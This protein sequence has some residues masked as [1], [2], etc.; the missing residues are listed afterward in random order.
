MSERAARE[1]FEAIL[2][3]YEAPLRRLAAAYEREPDRQ[4]DLLQEI[5]LALWRALPSFRGQSSERTFVYRVAHNR[6]LTHIAKRRPSQ[7]E[8]DAARDIPASSLGPEQSA[9]LRAERDELREAIA[10][11]PLALREVVLLRLEDLSN[12]EVAHVLGISE[13][14]VA[15]RLA[16]ARKQLRRGGTSHV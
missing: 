11:L 10:S 9:L 6:A 12:G 7:L 13:G 5:H 4:D 8:L 14:N 16:R 15:V 1:H 3:E 2:L